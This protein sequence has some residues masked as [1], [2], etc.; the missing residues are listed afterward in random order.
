VDDL[1]REDAGPQPAWDTRGSEE[2]SERGP[3]FL[4]FFQVLNYTQHIFPG[5]AKNF[6]GGEKLPAPP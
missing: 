1:C 3:K 6:S 4:N 5:R 2:F